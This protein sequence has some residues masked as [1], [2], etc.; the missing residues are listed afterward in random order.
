MYTYVAFKL[1]Q[2]T[3]AVHLL[4]ALYLGRLHD[5]TPH[6]AHHIQSLQHRSHCRHRRFTR[7]SACPII[8]LLFYTLVAGGPFR[9]GCRENSGIVPQQRFIAANSPEIS[10]N[11]TLIARCLAYYI[12]RDKKILLSE[13]AFKPVHESLR[14]AVHAIHTVPKEYAHRSILASLSAVELVSTQVF[15]GQQAS[16]CKQTLFTSVKSVDT[17]M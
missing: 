1:D 11:R 5:P 15:F 6:Y 16:R 10:P 13:N 7:F 17:I 3:P 8:R 12:A 14:A 2:N 4:R 9:P